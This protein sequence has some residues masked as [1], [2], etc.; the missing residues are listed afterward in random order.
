MGCDIFFLALPAADEDELFDILLT[1]T[2]VGAAFALPSFDDD[3][4]IVNEG[5]CV[6]FEGVRRG[7]SVIDDVYTT[8]T[9]FM[10]LPCALLAFDFD[11]KEK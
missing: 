8:S 7:L 9:C 2:L 1:F 6:V 4:A 5:W 11:F 3:L 10:S